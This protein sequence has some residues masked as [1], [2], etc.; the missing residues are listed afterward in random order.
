MKN[1]I[2]LSLSLCFIIAC[3]KGGKK[4]AEDCPRYETCKE[5]LA[6]CQS[7]TTVTAADTIIYDVALNNSLSDEWT[8]ECLRGLD[9][10]TLVD[11]FI[12]GVASEKLKAVNFETGAP[13]TTKD[14]E[15]LKADPKFKTENIGKIQFVEGWE[16]DTVNSIL[17]KKIQSATI[18]YEIFNSNGETM[19][20]KAAFTVVF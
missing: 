3:N 14:L 10:K 15:A 2:V 11:F 4:V 13:F 6:C 16:I 9:K 18:G 7:K 19:G 17:L 5:K 8:A 20:N 1:I 12:Q